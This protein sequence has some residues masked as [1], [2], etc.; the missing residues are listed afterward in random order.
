MT[1]GAA[2]PSLDDEELCKE[3]IEV[4]LVESSVVS[5]IVIFLEA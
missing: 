5:D 2:E 1:I 4:L 3:V